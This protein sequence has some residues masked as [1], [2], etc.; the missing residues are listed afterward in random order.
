MFRLESILL[1][2]LP[3]LMGNL[4][5]YLSSYVLFNKIKYYIRKKKKEEEKKEIRGNN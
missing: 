2:D 5:K 1:S 3:N 4:I